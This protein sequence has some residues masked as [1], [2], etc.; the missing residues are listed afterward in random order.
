MESDCGALDADRSRELCQG[1]PDSLAG[2]AAIRLAMPHF[3]G[4][5]VSEAEV[6]AATH[7]TLSVKRRRPSSSRMRT[8]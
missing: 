5:R 8:L 7:Y 1:E 3:L 4:L 6:L 2:N